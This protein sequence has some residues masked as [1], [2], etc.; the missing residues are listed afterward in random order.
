MADEECANGGCSN[1]AAKKGVTGPPRRYCSDRCRQAA[2]RQRR[3]SQPAVTVAT[4]ATDPIGDA[5]EHVNTTFAALPNPARLG[6]YGRI[7]MQVATSLE[8]FQKATARRQQ[9]G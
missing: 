6:D 4:V 7:V 1:D 3:A 9:R 8:Q 2:Y 5:I